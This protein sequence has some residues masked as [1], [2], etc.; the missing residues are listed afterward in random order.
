MPCIYYSVN[1]Y[2]IT[3]YTLILTSEVNK[4]P[5]ISV[6]L[7]SNF[8]TS[9]AFAVTGW[10]LH[11]SMTFLCLGRFAN[12]STYALR[13]ILLHQASYPGLQASLQ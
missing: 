9:I 2:D 7:P 6:S 1:A 3:F 11:F 13:T 4:E 12:R 5:V 8:R 10:S